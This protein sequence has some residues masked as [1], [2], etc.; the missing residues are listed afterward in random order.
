MPTPLV[1]SYVALAIPDVLSKLGLE[2][3]SASST[4][5]T[6]PHGTGAMPLKQLVRV[7]K[8]TAHRTNQTDFGLKFGTTVSARSLGSFGMR[9]AYASSTDDTLNFFSSF[10]RHFQQATHFEVSASH[11][12]RTCELRYTAIDLGE[13]R[14]L[15]DA[16]LALLLS[17]LARF[18]DTDWQPTHVHLR[19]KPPAKMDALVTA[20]GPNIAFSQPFDGFTVDIEQANATTGQ[21][22]PELCKVLEELVVLGAKDWPEGQSTAAE[23]SQIITNKIEIG[24]PS[25]DSI[26]REMGMSTR[27]LQRRLRKEGHNFSEVVGRARMEFAEQ[28]LYEEQ[29]SITNLAFDLGY[30]D[31]A[32]FSRAF[33]RWLG[34]SPRAYMNAT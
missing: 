31:V 25:L 23:V 27:T 30:A 17:C 26:A 20:F 11:G 24:L 4:R 22:D 34:K 32:A 8:E 1:Q 3:T 15:L 7:L 21:Q 29:Q 5:C 6:E 2:P 16:E 14:H 10:V 33:R 19:R 18:H 12:V 9:L 13:T 28:R